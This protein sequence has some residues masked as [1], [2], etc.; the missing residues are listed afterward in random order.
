ME[1]NRPS[2]HENTHTPRRNDERLTH[3][4]DAAGL[5][6]ASDAPT[7]TSVRFETGN[8]ATDG[9]HCIECLGA[10]ASDAVAD[11]N[12]ATLCRTCAEFFYVACAACGGL[13]PRDEALPPN[14]AHTVMATAAAVAASD[15]GVNNGDGA[16]LVCASC[17]AG[18]LPEAIGA[19]E[20][21]TLVRQ[22]VEL[23]AEK[24]S[25]ETRLD[26]LKERLKA[27]AQGRQRVEG[28]VVMRAGEACV[29]VSY[30]MK[31]TADAERIAA[32]SS[33]FDAETFSALFKTTYSP[34][35]EKLEEFLADTDDGR[36]AAREALRDAIQQSEVQ[37]LTV[38]AQKKARATRTKKDS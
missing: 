19:E 6:S 2:Q 29:R 31:T 5:A 9:A 12:G 7:P 21:E 4:V 20:M 8:A 28:A 35:K 37:T 22:F 1:L 33:M 18:G 36:A 26:E 27:A 14:D 23:H 10:V 3:D 15:G 17:F 11:K 30:T 13:V 25:I 24:K 38:V 16:M 34:V 32:L